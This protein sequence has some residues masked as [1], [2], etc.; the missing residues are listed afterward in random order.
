MQSNGQVGIQQFEKKRLNHRY[1]L[2]ERMER[3][4]REEVTPRVAPGLGRWK[5]IDV[6]EENGTLKVEIMIN[7]KGQ[8]MRS[9]AKNPDGTLVFRKNGRKTD[10]TPNF[11]EAKAWEKNLEGWTQDQIL[12]T[13]L[14]MYRADA[15]RGEILN[16][17]SPLQSDVRTMSRDLIRNAIIPMEPRE[18]ERWPIRMAF[19]EIDYDNLRRNANEIARKK[20][21]DPETRKLATELFNPS[22]TQDGTLVSH[23]NKTVLNRAVFQELARS[24][25]HVIQYY[26]QNI[27][28]NHPAP[29]VLAH[30]GQVIQAVKKEVNLTPAEWKY[31]C[32]I[33]HG[34][35][36]PEYKDRR[37]QNIRTRMQALAEANQ[38][39]ASNRQII[40]IMWKTDHEQH[41]D[42]N[43]RGA[44]WKALVQLMSRYL[45]RFQ[46]NTDDPRNERFDRVLDALHGYW[47]A[48]MPW[49]PGDWDVLE[50]R[51]E[52][53][54]QDMNQARNQKQNDEI[55]NAVWTSL[56][57]GS[58][59]NKYHFQPVTNATDLIETSRQMHNCLSTYWRRCL[60]GSRRVFVVRL[61]AGTPDEQAPPNPNPSPNPTEEGKILAAV[62]LRRNGN[63]WRVGQIEAP[64]RR[65]FPQGIRT[66]SEKLRKM[67]QE[68]QQQ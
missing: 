39:Q 20:L 23:Y 47:D 36:S 29:V 8:A 44:R 22:K 18:T 5:L 46:E 43:Q 63:E 57:P 54:H 66:A 17:N 42:L 21:V 34:K 48:G 58:T 12:K 67:Y 62:E 53:W 4:I 51:S 27:A 52:K 61:Q 40:S 38:P 7:Q 32:R 49:G 2:D 25:I 16:P 59:I 35:T 31:F 1:L 6:R 65:Q 33:P 24:S 14:E 37:I 13:I 68:A 19:G 15:I 28:E 45:E 9:L 50:N 3:K 26:C 60:E 10:S 55:K 56:V 41:D 64:R 11:N 30:P